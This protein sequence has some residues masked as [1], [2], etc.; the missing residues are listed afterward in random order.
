MHTTRYGIFLLLWFGA[1][2]SNASAQTLM[3]RLE[4]NQ[5]RVSLPR[6]QLLIGTP[7]E[8]LRNGASVKYALQLILSHDRGG[9]AVARA[10]GRFVVSY[11]LWEEKF[12]VSRIEPSPRSISHLSAAAAEA[13]CL[14]SLSISAAGLAPERPFWLRL[15]FETEDPGDSMAP[16]DG[17]LTLSGL[18]EIFSRPKPDQQLRGSVEAGPL[19]LSDLRNSRP[20]GRR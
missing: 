8:R 18:I 13:W 3:V 19:R 4:A 7:V 2:G 15:D 11:D 9:R 12:A 14:E 17:G 10:I 16:A 20:G 5:L 6:Q 1:A